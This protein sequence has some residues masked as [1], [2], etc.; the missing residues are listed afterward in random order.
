M[1]ILALLALLLV[2]PA[3]GEDYLIDPAHTSVDFEITALG[4]FDQHGRF[5]RVRGALTLD[6]TRRGEMHIEIDADSIDTG[7]DLRDRDYRSARWFDTARYPTLIFH[8]RRFVF[9]GDR[10]V[11]IEGEL[12]LRGITR[13]LRFSVERFQCGLLPGSGRIG[14]SATAT[15]TLK[16]SNY[17]MDTYSLLVGDEVK[18]HIEV[19]MLRAA[20]ERE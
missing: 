14:C 19:E 7:L 9:E 12:T 17:G 4:L 10:L 3:L 5:D 20:A 15:A 13:S 18:L 8:S 6:E 11:A 16:R 2:Q 1:R